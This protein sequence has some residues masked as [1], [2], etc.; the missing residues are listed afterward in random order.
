M[1]HV[2]CVAAD[3]DG[4]L[5]FGAEGGGVTCLGS[6]GTILG[7]LDSENSPLP[8]DRVY[9]IGYNPERGSMFFS[10]SEGVAVMSGC[11]RAR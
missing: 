1:Q 6:D 4:R 3:G 11:R 9:G 7:S 8:S 2:N 5:W 10:T